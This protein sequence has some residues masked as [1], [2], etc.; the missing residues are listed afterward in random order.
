[1]I[2]DEL[3]IK[4]FNK[5]FEETF[6]DLGESKLS[7]DNIDEVRDEISKQI[8]SISQADIDKVDKM[9]KDAMKALKMGE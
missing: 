1:M 9:M 2:N 8:D 3:E 6:G 7:L 5:F 4:R